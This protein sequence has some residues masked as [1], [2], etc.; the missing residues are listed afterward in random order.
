MKDEADEVAERLLE[1]LDVGKPL[2]VC[3]DDCPKVVVTRPDGG[4]GGRFEGTASERDFFCR[5]I[6]RFR[7]C[8]DSYDTRI[9]ASPLPH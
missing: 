8:F 7:L 3:E 1:V 2:I 4:G 6:V 9:S 5:D